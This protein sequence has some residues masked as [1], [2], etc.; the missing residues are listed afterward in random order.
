MNAFWLANQSIEKNM[1]F[2]SGLIKTISQSKHLTPT[3]SVRKNLRYLSI[4]I[5]SVIFY[6]KDI[7]IE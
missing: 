6:Y 7:F 3:V 1:T 2:S 5:W 4:A